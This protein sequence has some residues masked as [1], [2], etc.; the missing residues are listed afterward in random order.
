MAA[1]NAE[2]RFKQAFTKIIVTRYHISTIQSEGY[3]SA[4]T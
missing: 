4:N 1:K 3:L 2:H